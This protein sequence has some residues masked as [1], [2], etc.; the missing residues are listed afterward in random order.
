MKLHGTMEIKDGQLEIGHIAVKQLAKQFGTPLY[1]FDEAEF[2]NQSQKFLNSFDSDKFETKVYYAGKT[3]SNLYIFGL[4]QKLGL[5]LDVVSE[6]ELYTALRAGVDTNNIILHGNNKLKRELEMTLDYK[7][8]RIVIDHPV[9]YHL[10]SKM[11]SERQQKTKVLLRINPGIVADTHKYI[12]TST[13]DS[14]FGMNSADPSTYKLLQEIAK[15]PY[16]DLVGVHCHIGSQVLNKK[17]FFEEAEAMLQFLYNLKK[18]YNINLTELNLGGGFGVYYTSEDHPFDLEEFLQDYIKVIENKIT[19]Y[20]LQVEK[21]S[22]EPGRALINDSGSLLYQIGAVKYPYQGNPYIFVDGGM[23][24]NIR[25][26]LYQ[27]KYEACLPEKMNNETAASF[28]VAGKCCES[29]DILIEKVDLPMPE[30]DDLL[31][32]PASGA[33][34]FSMSSNYNRLPKPAVVF[35]N[36]RQAKLAVKREDYADLI[37]NDLKYKEEDN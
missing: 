13:E 15:D 33:Y 5:S 24:D 31:L 9:E 6:G 26:A 36:E 4:V 7:I 19:E 29:G 30:R 27:A 20:D 11:C 8:G 10:L 1:I 37:R 18:D 35:V 12:K 14:K 32:I 25:P 22:I 16:I 2:I 23:T 3:F 17:F 34:T 21:V 28:K